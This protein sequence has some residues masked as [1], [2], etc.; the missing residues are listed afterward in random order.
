MDRLRNELGRGSIGEQVKQALYRL[1]SL[2][3]SDREV[4]QLELAELWRDYV[5]VLEDFPMFKSYELHIDSDIL[6]TGKRG[7]EFYFL[8]I[9]RGPPAQ[10]FYGVRDTAVTGTTV[11]REDNARFEE[12]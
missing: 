8:A 2:K 7:T 9:T 6:F 10:L 11:W 3:A 1:R 12:W 4:H 5:W